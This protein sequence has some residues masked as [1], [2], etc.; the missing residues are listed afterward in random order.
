[1]VVSQLQLECAAIL[2][3]LAG[4]IDQEVVLPHVEANA[5]RDFAE[6]RVGME[7]G[8]KSRR[9]VGSQAFDPTQ[10]RLQVVGV[11]FIREE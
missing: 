1:M 2:Y 3:S 10:E 5:R 6:A 11:T 4:P 9:A 8:R 7:H